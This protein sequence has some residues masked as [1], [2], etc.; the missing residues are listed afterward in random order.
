MLAGI[1]FQVLSLLIFITICVEFAI[2]VHKHKTAAAR[3]WQEGNGRGGPMKL[4]GFLC[5]L[6][7]A[8]M[9][10]LIR[11]VFRVVE[12]NG[13]FN[14]WVANQEI[15]FMI[16]EGGAMLVACIAL[17]IYHPGRVLFDHWAVGL[18]GRTVT[19]S[20]T[21][22]GI[23]KKPFVAGDGED[24]ETEHFIA[25]QGPMAGFEM[26][27]VAAGGGQ[28]VKVADPNAPRYIK[29]T[30]TTD[31]N[32]DKFEPVRIQSQPGR[33]EPVRTEYG[34]AGAVAG[35]GGEMASYGEGDIAEYGATGRRS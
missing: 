13:G 16:F 27:H 22:M 21:G 15:L 20:N 3:S 34:G 5:A 26:S 24:N 32:T 35:S 12:M 23:A 2:R 31:P 33:F 14:S 8:T 25:N 9:A 10:I 17:T 28:Y 30:A 19:N 29:D 4:T 7:L 6:T 11:S 18:S 1:A